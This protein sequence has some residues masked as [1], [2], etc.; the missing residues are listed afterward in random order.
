MENVLMI[1]GIAATVCLLALYLTYGSES[2]LCDAKVG[3]TFNFEYLQPLHGESER[4]LAR[5]IEPVYKLNDEQISRLNS[6]SNYRRNDPE[7]QRTNHL[8]TCQTKDGQIRNFY[9]ERVKNCRKSLLGW[10]L[11]S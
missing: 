11:A 4:Y 3:D 9:C 5:V 1:L 10:L 6:R 2:S 7:F 8:V